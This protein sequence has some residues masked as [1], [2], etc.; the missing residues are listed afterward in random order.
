ME[1][2]ACRLHSSLSSRRG[3]LATVDGTSPRPKELSL[4][5]FAV[6]EIEAAL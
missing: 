1:T 4:S 3:Y 2:G 6:T 5:K